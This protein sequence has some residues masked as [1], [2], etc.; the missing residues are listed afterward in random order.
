MTNL[1]YN[2]GLC[3]PSLSFV[4]KSVVTGGGLRPL[5]HWSL[6]IWWSFLD[7]YKPV[8]VV[9]FPHHVRMTSH[10][11]DAIWHKKWR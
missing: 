3:W 10:N 7:E 11:L 4:A 5:D 2:L 1:E 6:D 9:S 8:T